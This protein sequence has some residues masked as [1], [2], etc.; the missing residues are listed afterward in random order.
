V[1]RKGGSELTQSGDG[2][3]GWSRR[4]LMQGMSCNKLSE[5]SNTTPNNRVM[6]GDSGSLTDRR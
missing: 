5:S 6:G 4:A 3:G 1:D 2:E